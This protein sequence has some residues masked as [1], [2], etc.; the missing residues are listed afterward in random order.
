MVEPSQTIVDVGA[1]YDRLHWTVELSIHDLTNQ[2]LNLAVPYYDS[3][4]DTA[5]YKGRE[6]S[7]DWQWRF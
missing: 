1:V 4:F 5:P 2:R 7:V 3:G 6:F